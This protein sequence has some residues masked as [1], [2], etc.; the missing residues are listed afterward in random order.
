MQNIYGKPEV[1]QESNYPM[2]NE[3]LRSIAPMIQQR[4]KEAEGREA[5]AI[6]EQQ[7]IADRPAIQ[8][9]F[10]IQQQERPEPPMNVRYDASGGAGMTPYQMAQLA[11]RDKGANSLIDS[12]I[13]NLDIADR[14]TDLL[15]AGG[16][17]L[18]QIAAQAAHKTGQI[19]QTAGHAMARLGVTGDQ[20]AAR[21]MSNQTAAMRRV[22]R[23]GEIQR[24]LQELR[25][26][27]SAEAIR[28]RAELERE[29][30]A[31]QLENAKELKAS[32]GE[33]KELPPSQQRIAR[34]DRAMQLLNDHPEWKKY[35]KASKDGFSITKSGDPQID[36]F[37]DAAIYTDR[38][39]PL[40][41]TQDIELPSGNQPTTTTT[42]P[43]SDKRARAIAALTKAGKA[44][45]DKTIAM[46]M[47]RLK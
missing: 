17:R 29:D 33:Q 36:T 10:P 43:S 5:A 32:P 21:D 16:S 39:A 1:K 18:D 37:I 31:L 3:F 11:I 44:V 12:R 45:N 9:N 24:N 40:N 35:I 14:K 47:A 7:T 30:R 4:R 23:Q 15:E 20:N 26:V 8:P 42:A 19:D 25:G 46:V 22:E 28:L 6:Q 27:Q 2:Y 38:E 13:G 41:R 34:N